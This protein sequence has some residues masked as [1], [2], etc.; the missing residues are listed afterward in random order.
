MDSLS[1]AI[2]WVCLALGA[3]AILAGVAVAMKYKNVTPPEKP[4]AE[5]VGDQGAVGDVIDKTTEFAKALKDLDSSG[6]LLTVGVL[7]IAISGVVAGL[8]NI[9]DAI[10]ATAGS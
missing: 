1:Q 7:L 3:I 6:R 2:G 4:A 9:A 5:V 8:D 10:E